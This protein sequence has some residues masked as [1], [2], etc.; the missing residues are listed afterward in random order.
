MENQIFKLFI[1]DSNTGKLLKEEDYVKYPEIQKET[2]E[3]NQSNPNERKNLYL[4]TQFPPKGVKFNT[5]IKQFVAKLFSEQVAD[6]EV[7]VPAD[8]KLIGE[9]LVRLS[10]KEL[11]EKGLL[12]LEF[13]EKI[14]EF[15]KVVKMD[16]KDMYK[17][18][19]ASKYQL[20]QHMLAELGMKIDKIAKEAFNYP[21]QEMASWHLKKDQSSKWLAQSTS[22]KT[23]LLTGE[24]Y[25]LLAYDLLVTEAFVGKPNTLSNNEKIKAVDDKAQ[26]ILDKSKTYETFHGELFGRRSIAKDKLKTLMESD[27]P[28]MVEAMELVLNEF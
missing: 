26:T 13:D 14:D 19:K 20:Y 22:E 8:Q 28:N 9:T 16:I 15:D 3:W 23:D 10:N 6:G 18:N 25:G 11:F 1:F 5:E 17:A 12:K 4:G 7:E 24:K 21:V 27:A 2:I